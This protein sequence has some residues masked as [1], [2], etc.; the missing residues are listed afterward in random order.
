[1]TAIFTYMKMLDP[2]SVVRESEFSAA[3]STAGIMQQVTIMGNQLLEGDMLSPE[4]RAEFL[5]LA[6]IFYKVTKDYTDQKRI[7]MGFILENNPS[8][9]FSNVFGLQYPPPK[10]YLN[11]TIKAQVDG[12]SITMQELW[13]E[14]NEAEK[15]EYQ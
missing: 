9:K 13:D 15:R 4:Q 8:L 11:S 5:D 6:E 14:M 2:G 12:S 1:M 10:F 7:N 3:Q